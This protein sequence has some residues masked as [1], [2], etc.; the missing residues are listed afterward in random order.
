MT[1]T[2]L[3]TDTETTG[4]KRHGGLIQEGQARICQSAMILTDEKGKKLGEF[5]TLIKPDGWVIS[6]GAYRCNGI[7]MEDCY[8]HGIAQ[9]AFMNTW[10]LFVSRADFIVAHNEKFDREMMEIE[11]AYHNY[12]GSYNNKPWLCTMTTNTHIMGGKGLK[13]CVRHYLGRE[14]SKAHDAMGDTIDCMEIFFAM[15]GIRM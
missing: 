13:N 2:Y 11:S 3:F 7:K 8:A 6:D 1:E 15:R 12:N 9:S 5:S 4:F 14:P 10:E